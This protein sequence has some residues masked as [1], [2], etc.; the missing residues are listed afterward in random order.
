MA[1][2]ILAGS[3]ELRLTTRA[4]MLSTVRE[5]VNEFLASQGADAVFSY[6]VM[7]AADEV[8]ANVFEHAYHQEERNKRLVLTV[9]LQP[10]RVEII[11]KDQ[12]KPFR[13]PEKR[14]FDLAKHKRAGH[15]RGYGLFFIG[16]LMDSVK[17]RRHAGWNEIRLR[18][19]LPP[20]Q[21]RPN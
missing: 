7:S 12:G 15:Q 1:V 2:P 6:L 19:A 9:H 14:P 8:V 11:V 17:Y 16:K 18:K 4:P 20:G 13:P 5:S 21:I 3:M 10:R